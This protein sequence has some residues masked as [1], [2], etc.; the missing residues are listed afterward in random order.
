MSD[1]TINAELRET[2]GKANARRMRRAGQIPGII[3]GGGKPDLAITL[4][5]NATGKLLNTDEFHTSMLEVAVKGKRGKNTVLL[6][7]VQWD[8]ITDNPMHLDFFRVSSSDI[9]TMDI[10]VEAI[11]SETCPGVVQGGMLSLVRHTLEVSSRADAIPDTIVVDCANLEIGDTI[12]IEDI[13]L[14]E[15]CEVHHDVNFTVLAIVAPKTHSDDDAEEGTTEEATAEATAPAAE[16]T[17]PAA[18]A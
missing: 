12:H 8:S 11:N 13:T 3:Y 1:L 5:A 18:E 6:K 16:A 17:A 14:P 9:V 15:G 10:P 2:T 7:D 4:D